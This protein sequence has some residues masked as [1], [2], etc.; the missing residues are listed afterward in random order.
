MGTIAQDYPELRLSSLPHHGQQP[1]IEL[2]LRGNNE[3]II[4]AMKLMT[5][6]I[7]IAGF[8]WPDQLGESK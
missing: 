6:A 5:E 8:S 3:S 7:D 2:S 1:H 4:K